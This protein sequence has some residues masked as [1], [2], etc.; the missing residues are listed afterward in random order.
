MRLLAGVALVGGIVT[1][2]EAHPSLIGVL[3]AFSMII[4]AIAVPIA[5]IWIHP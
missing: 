2:L 3:M 5:T 4:L 1:L